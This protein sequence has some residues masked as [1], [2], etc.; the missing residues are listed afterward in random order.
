MR[1]WTP[2]ELQKTFANVIGPTS[3]SVDGYFGLG[4]QKS[5]LDMLPPKY[6]VIVRCS[7]VLRAMSRRARWMLQFADSIYVKSKRR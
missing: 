6:Q 4:I 2:A 7:E 3:L 5:D 1:Y